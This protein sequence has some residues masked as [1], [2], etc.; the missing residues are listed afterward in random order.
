MP[1]M[2]FVDTSVDIDRNGLVVLPRE[3]CLRLLGTAVIGRVAVTIGALPAV[4]P[5]NFVV[6]GDDVVFRSSPGTKLEAAVDGAVVAF[7]V[8]AIDAISHAG[9]SVLVTGRASVLTNPGDL[10]IAER[11]PLRGWA[12]SGPSSFV[13]IRGE[14]I[15]G[16]RLDPVLRAAASA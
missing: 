10:A 9:W 6:C 4:F 7:E 1:T 15:S 12:E 8:D 16:R 3:E 11:L 5:V 2:S 14:I 13:R